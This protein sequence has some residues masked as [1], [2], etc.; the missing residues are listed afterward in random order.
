MLSHN[1]GTDGG[2]R[3]EE[4]GRSIFSDEGQGDSLALISRT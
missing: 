1:T 3:W 2:T 4:R